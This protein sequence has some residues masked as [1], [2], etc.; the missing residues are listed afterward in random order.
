MEALKCATIPVLIGMNLKLPLNNLIAW[1]EIVI[2]IPIAQTFNVNQILLNIRE[3]ELLARQIKASNI[4]NNYFA[5]NTKVFRTIF[6]AVQWKLNMPL[7]SVENFVPVEAQLEGWG[8]IH[9]LVV[10]SNLLYRFLIFN[11]RI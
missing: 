4:W 1:N 2:Q 9:L 11:F 8:I 7:A 5:T 3:S 10:V 6:A